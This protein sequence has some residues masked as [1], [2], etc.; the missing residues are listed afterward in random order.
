MKI[1]SDRLWETHL[2]AA[3]MTEAGSPY[4]RRS[5][6]PQYREMRS[7]LTD[8]FAQTGLEVKTDAAGNLLGIYRGRTEKN[9]G[10]GS[11][12]DTVPCGGRFDG[13]S[14]VL[15]FLEAARC[16]KE[17]GYVPQ[18]NIVGIDFLAEEPSEF[19]L[20][21][22]GSR[23]A[24]GNFNENMLQLK[25]R[26]TGELLSAAI[27]DWGGDISLLAPGHSLFDA[28]KFD[29][30]LELHIE[31][32]PVLE[33]KQLDVG[34]VTGICSV[35]RY[36]FTVK[37]RADH[38][39]NTPMNLRSDAV[40]AAAKLI[41]GI[42]EIARGTLSK[43]PYFTA[44]VGKVDVFP[45]GSN[46]IAEQVD[47]T[48]DIRCETNQLVDET[49]QDI[50]ALAADTAGKTATTISH[51]KIS[52]SQPSISSER[53]LSVLEKNAIELN[54]QYTRMLSGA[55][56]D[57]AYMST[58]MPMAM[59]FIPCRKGRS[60]TASEYS[61]KHQIAKGA[62]LLLQSLIELTSSD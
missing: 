49:L 45:N 50:F 22:I 36:D 5:F 10:V 57:A 8:A 34:L 35:T 39:G 20:S 29:G 19:R 18:K 4:T 61:A 62:N 2:A 32:G 60:H 1:N 3:T 52:Q 27:Q 59:I 42:S 14:G 47:F 28:T 25:H 41:N 33:K 38:A 44:T 58:V 24:T 31:Q 26:Q 9:V 46:V 43:G 7:W 15:S 30:F 56:H 23:L 51:V 21:C 16:M 17:N 48:L 53:L 11:H 13:I 55:G 12:T 37:G 54:L 6:T 40:V